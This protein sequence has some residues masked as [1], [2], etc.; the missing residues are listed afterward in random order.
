MNAVPGGKIQLIWQAVAYGVL[1]GYYTGCSGGQNG[2]GINWSRID[3]A[4]NRA[5]D[6]STYIHK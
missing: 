2:S 3:E 6:Q 1:S 4:V 5:F